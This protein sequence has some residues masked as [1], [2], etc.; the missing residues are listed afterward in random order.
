MLSTAGMSVAI[1]IARQFTLHETSMGN[2]RM[3]STAG[4]SPMSMLKEYKEALRTIRSNRLVWSF[5]GVRILG[6][7]SSV[8]WSTYA[9]VYLTSQE[10]ARLPE[11]V[12]SFVPALSAVVTLLAVLLTARRITGQHLFANMVIGQLIWLVGAVV[13]LLSP[14]QPAWMAV[15]WTIFN[16]VSLVLFQPAGMSYWANIVDERQRALIF[17]T[18]TALIALFTLPIGPLA[19]Y[20]YMASPRL[21]FLFALFIQVLALAVIVVTVRKEAT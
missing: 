9:M 18:A 3:S 21:P 1:A 5:L 13:F 6:A 16:A 11:A 17:S 8:V 20:L 19:G 7:A 2:Q 12:V 15:L 4:S 14:L 10:G